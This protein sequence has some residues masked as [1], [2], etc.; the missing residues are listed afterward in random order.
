MQQRG[1]LFLGGQIH[2]DYRTFKYDNRAMTGS[3]FML[4]ARRYA[5][6]NGQEYRL[7]PSRGKGSHQRLWIGRSFTTV[8]RGELKPGTFRGMLKQLNISKED[9]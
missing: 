7:E 9:F 3:E 5:R 2:L 1:Q 8:Q 6:R 4:R